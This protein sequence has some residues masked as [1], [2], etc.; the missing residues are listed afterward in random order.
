M[1][2][3]FYSTVS[4]ILIVVALYATVE[5]AA[6]FCSTPSQSTSASINCKRDY[7][8]S[9]RRPKKTR[10]FRF[11][12]LLQTATAGMDSTQDTPGT[13]TQ[14]SSTSGSSQTTQTRTETTARAFETDSTT[15]ASKNLNQD[16]EKDNAGVVGNWE[17]LYGN[18]VLRPTFA[19]D[20]PGVDDFDVANSQPRA[21]IHFLGGALVGKAPHVTYRYLLEKLAA[22]G[23]LIVATPFDLSF[24][25][26]AACDQILTKFEAVAPT[27]A[28]QY[29]A[30]PVVGIGHSC[31]ALLQVL[32]SSLF[33]DT[34]RAANALLS[35]NNKPVSEAVPFFDE[36]FAPV[37][38]S[39]AVGPEMG[40]SESGGESNTPK[41]GPSP[42]E[43]L[44]MGLKLAKAASQGN[45]P[46]DDLLQ[47][48]QRLFGSGFQAAA[49]SLPVPI[50]PF[51]GDDRDQSIKIPT[52]IRETY[53]KWAEPSVNALSEAGVLPI[54]HETI[55]S[56]E[57]I[58]KLIDE[59]RDFDSV[60]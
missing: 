49:A 60:S 13:T 22:E 17:N 29:G 9:T 50:P 16:S 31:G 53:A 27:L 35:F 32:I 37:F 1:G 46:S 20:V 43:S 14:V 5:R 6:A 11:P 18:W 55:V 21:V 4:M 19:G 56:L 33:P 44:V 45:L 41:R 24:D 57:Q 40:G 58:P 48:A 3:S 25:H 15:Q 23:F 12:S 28:K 36:F 54:I 8:R 7:L 34:P 30:L 26:L 39:L 51:L 2:P 52:E 10:K 42:N 38:S 59:V 47:E